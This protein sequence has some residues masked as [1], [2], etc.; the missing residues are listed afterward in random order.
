MIDF[1]RDRAIIR[2][3]VFRKIQ[4]YYTVVDLNKLTYHLL[5]DDTKVNHTNALKEMVRTNKLDQKKTN[6]EE[7]EHN[8]L[9]ENLLSI[10]SSSNFG[11]FRKTE[12]LVSELDEKV[13]SDGIN[14]QFYCSYLIKYRHHVL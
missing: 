1:F 12:S 13:I 2:R 8:I 14:F 10:N 3:R 7:K 11:I 9:S 5:K 4:K 6:E